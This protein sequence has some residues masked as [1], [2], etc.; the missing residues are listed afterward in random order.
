MATT[1]RNLNANAEQRFND[2]QVKKT[3]SSQL[4][5]RLADANTVVE[6]FTK[7]LDLKGTWEGADSNKCYA[8]L[9]PTIASVERFDL[10]LLT[11]DIDVIN[12][13]AYDKK[14][15]IT[16]IT[17]DDDFHTE[18]RNFL[19]ANANCTYEAWLDHLVTKFSNSVAKVVA[20]PYTYMVNKRPVQFYMLGFDFI[21][22]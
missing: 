2:K 1:E 22:K 9:V 7:Y 3:A 11:F 18:S 17:P 4:V 6:K 13:S 12:K 20:I 19:T 8:G 16:Y 10:T 21:K 15:E 5:K 14:G